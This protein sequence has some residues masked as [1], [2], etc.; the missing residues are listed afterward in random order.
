MITIITLQ[1]TLRVSHS[2]ELFRK[3]AYY[4]NI[5]SPDKKFNYFEYLTKTDF[6]IKKRYPFIKISPF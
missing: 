5:L 2:K 4:I 1:A 6:K 3:L